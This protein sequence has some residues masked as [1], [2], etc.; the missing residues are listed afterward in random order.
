MELGEHSITANALIRAR[1]NR[2]DS[3]KSVWVNQ[4]VIKGLGNQANKV[5]GAEY[6]VTG[7]RQRQA[8][9]PDS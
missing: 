8:E 3:T 2:F 6:E 5:T 7:G 9:A 1:R 4:W